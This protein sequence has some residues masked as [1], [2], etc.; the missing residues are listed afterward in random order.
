MRSAASTLGDAFT[1]M[2]DTIKSAFDKIKGVAAK[3]VN[4]IINT[5]YNDGIKKAFDT[6]ASKVGS[7]ARLPKLN[8]VSGYAQG[9]VLPGYTPGRDVHRF[10]SPTGGVIDLSGGEGIIRPDA[11]RRLGGAAWLNAVNRSRGKG[12]APWGDAGLST[13]YSAFKDGGIWGGITSFASAA[14]DKVTAA[15]DFVADVVSDPLAAFAD[16]ITAPARALLGQ[17][18][19]TEWG[20][21]LAGIPKLLANAVRDFFKR[22]TEEVGGGCRTGQHGPQV[23]WHPV[24]VGR[25][26]NP[27]G[28]D[29]S[30]WCIT[31]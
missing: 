4:F 23:P 26:V 21:L 12:F 8:P 20:S 15:G 13:H 16:L 11:L 22:D 31:R 9:G 1:S 27:P 7:K 5:V 17:I 29:C 19:D 25:V 28:L 18:K 14:W 10:W 3:P 2:K 24:C 6:I 30:A